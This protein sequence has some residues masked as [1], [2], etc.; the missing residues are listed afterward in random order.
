MSGIFEISLIVDEFGIPHDAKY[1]KGPKE[2][3]FSTITINSITY[4]KFKP[5]YKNNIPVKCK[6]IIPFRF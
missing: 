2:F 5:A 4:L 1:I 3:N 6:I